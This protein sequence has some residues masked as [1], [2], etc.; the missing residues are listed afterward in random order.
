MPPPN[1]APLHETILKRFALNDVL[2]YDVRAA[3]RP[4]CLKG[5]KDL[6]VYAFVEPPMTRADIFWAFVDKI[7]ESI[8]KGVYRAIRYKKTNSS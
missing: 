6:A 5:H 8:G 7:K 2:Q 1:D 4:Y 3:Y